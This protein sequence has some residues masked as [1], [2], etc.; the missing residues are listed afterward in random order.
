MMWEDF[1]R[2][3]ERNFAE[4]GNEFMRTA[5]RMWQK[6]IRPVARF[7][8][9]DEFTA[10]VWP[11]GDTV[12]WDEMAVKGREGPY[13]TSELLFL[14]MSAG[15]ALREPFHVVRAL[16]FVTDEATLEVMWDALYEIRSGEAW[17]R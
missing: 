7:V 1:Q 13:A 15:I 5:L 17:R 12:D 8:R 3:L 9:D 4:I 14:S 6:P 2:T 10:D 11:A 16:D